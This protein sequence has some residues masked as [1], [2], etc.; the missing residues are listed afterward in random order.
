MLACT[1]FILTS[2]HQIS[3]TVY[4]HEIS[5]EFDYGSNQTRSVRVICPL[6]GK[7]AIFDFV[8]TLAST[9]INQSAPNSVKIYMIIRSLMSV[10]MGLIRP[11]QHVLEQLELF[12]LEL[13]KIDEFDFVYTLA[14]ANTGQ[15]APNLVKKM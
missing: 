14:S 15:A 8:Y 2:Q 10:I 6:M 3:Q 12:T 7:I 4:D 1:K 11:K 9:N 13:G 5:D